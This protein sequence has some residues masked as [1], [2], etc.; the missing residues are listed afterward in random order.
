MFTVQQEMHG[1]WA[2]IAHT[3]RDENVH[4][5]GFVMIMDLTGV[6]AKHMT[7]WNIDDLRKWHSCWQVSE[8]NFF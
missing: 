3:N 6:G 8:K 2:V 5:N 1:A 7:R 4:V